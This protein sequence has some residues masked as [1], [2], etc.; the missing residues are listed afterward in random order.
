M[1]DGNETTKPE[2]IESIKNDDS[3]RE[4]SMQFKESL[5]LYLVLCVSIYTTLNAANSFSVQLYIA[6]CSSSFLI[7]FGGYVKAIKGQEVKILLQRLKEETDA[8]LKSQRLADT[9]ESRINLLIEQNKDLQQI[10]QYLQTEIAKYTDLLSNPDQ[11]D[12]I[13]NILS[14]LNFLKQT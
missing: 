9:L 14:K 8:K 10:K 12:S 4:F 13:K 11:L 1:M 3:K 6:L 5:Y 2:H 7:I